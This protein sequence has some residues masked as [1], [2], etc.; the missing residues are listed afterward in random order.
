VPQGYGSYPVS[1]L[2]M[3]ENLLVLVLALIWDI[4]LGE[5]PRWMHPVVG[6]GKIIFL[7]VRFA[8]F[9]SRPLTQFIYGG[10]TVILTLSLLTFAFYVLLSYLKGVS[11]ALYML[12]GA[13]LLKSTFSLKELHQ[14]ARRV[15][16]DLE[17][18]DLSKARADIRALV[19]RDTTSLEKPLL[20]S[21][22]VESVA[23]NTSDGFVAPLLFFLVLGIPG[24]IAYRIANSYDSMIGYRGKYEYVGKFA[25]RLDD[26]LN[27]IPARI[28]AG[29]TIAAAFMCRKC[30]R[31]A[32]RVLLRDNGQTRSPNAGWPMSAAAG[33]L[34]VQL[35]K[36]GFYRLGDETRALDTGMI[37]SGI[38][39]MR[40]A[41]FA[42]IL[43]ALAVMVVRVV[44]TG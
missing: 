38:Q 22:T 7:Q 26:V 3:M 37:A 11:P 20:V 21:A 34:Q 1:S 6:L 24:A 10:V 39:L 18:D 35:V 31:G 28:T 8:P 29:L 40:M 27:F 17:K 33:A 32:W 4:A 41:A 23:E 14:A 12:A 5:P 36:V 43:A 19:G 16:R 9:R 13:F 44:I 42:W 15:K 25:A 2:I 30:A